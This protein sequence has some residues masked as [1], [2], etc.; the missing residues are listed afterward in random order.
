MKSKRSILLAIAA[1]I[2]LALVGAGSATAGSLITS[3]QIKDG[4]IQKRDLT[5]QA[6]EAF[7]AEGKPGVQGEQ[8]EQGLQGEPGNDG[9]D[10]TSE[11]WH[12]HG[13]GMVGGIGGS[14]VERSSQIGTVWLPEAGTYM[15]NSDVFFNGVRGTDGPRPEGTTLMLGI[16]DD[17]TSKVDYGTCFTP[18]FPD[19]DR[20][21]TCSTVR[22]VKVTERTRLTVHVFGYNADRSSTGSDNYEAFINVTATRLVDHRSQS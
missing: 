6:R 21:A 8:G 16:R 18:V 11:V 12:T 1:L 9:Q 17:A 4:T 2:V 20:E 5:P 22:R 14:F 10:G 19:G 3:K 13:L 15:I 7:S